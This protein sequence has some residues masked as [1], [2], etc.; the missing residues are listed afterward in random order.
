MNPSESRPGRLPVIC[1]RLAL[2][3]AAPA[4]DDTG[5]GLP[6]SV[7]DLST[8][9]VLSHPGE[10]V[11][12]VCSLLH[13]RYWLRLIRQVGRSHLRNEAET[14]SHDITADAFVHHRLRR[15]NRFRRRC[16]DYMRVEQFTW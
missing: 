5:P 6:G 1:S 7:I 10:P 12:C 16:G 3:S 4:A 11:R 15:Q 14:G 13:G 8:P 2:S 9:A